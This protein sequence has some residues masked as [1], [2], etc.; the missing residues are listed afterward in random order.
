[1]ND[2]VVMMERNRRNNLTANISRVT[3]DQYKDQYSDLQWELHPTENAF[4]FFVE[5]RGVKKI[6]SRPGLGL[7][8][9]SSRDYGIEGKFCP[10]WRD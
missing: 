9:N 2:V 3:K 4:N 8:Q 5:I 6:M 7:G 10:G 1:M